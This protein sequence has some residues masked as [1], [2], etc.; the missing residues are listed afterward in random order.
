MKDKLFIFAVIAAC[1][2]IFGCSDDKITSKLPVFDKLTTDRELYS[3]G[4]TVKTT[5]TF[6]Y[7]GYYVKGVYK[8]NVAPVGL[9]GSFELG[10][11]ESTS[12][13]FN[14]IAPDE[15]G[16]YTI[17]LKCT[18]MAAYAGDALY[19]DPAPMGSVSATFTVQ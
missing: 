5:L 4:D 16:D 6:S 15:P 17:T 7:S 13:T 12:H 11:S 8:F 2:T 1:L 10:A 9:S 19:L 14:I 3:A 18:S